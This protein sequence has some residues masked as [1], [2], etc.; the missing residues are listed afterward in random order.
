MLLSSITK[1]LIFS[2]KKMILS[3]NNIISASNDATTVS[4]LGLSTDCYMETLI[5]NVKKKL[6]IADVRFTRGSR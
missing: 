5:L 1:S 3:Q 4:V 6:T 2:E